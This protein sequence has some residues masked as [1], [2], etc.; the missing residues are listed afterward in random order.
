MSIVDVALDRTAAITAATSDRLNPILIKET[1][2]ATQSKLFSTVFLMFVAVSWLVLVMGTLSQWE[3]LETQPTAE[4]FFAWNF[5]VLSF[6]ILVIVPFGSYRSLLAER[7]L[8]TYDLLRITALSPR[9]IVRGKLGTSLLQIVVYYSAIAPFI[10]FTSVLQGFDV[11]WISWVL[12]MSFLWSMALCTGAL[13]TGISSRQNQWQSANMVGLIM[14]LLIDWGFV[15]SFV[16]AGRSAVNFEDPDF[17]WVNGLTLLAAVSYVILAGQ[18]I[19]ARL[20]FASGNR[21]TGIRVV[22][23]AQFWLVVGLLWLLVSLDNPIVLGSDFQINVG[24]VVLL[25]WTGAGL[26]LVTESDFL[27]RRIRRRLPVRRLWR[28]LAAPFLPGGAT[29]TVLVFAHLMLIGLGLLVAGILV[30][31][32]PD[33]AERI[34]TLVIILLNVIIWVG[35]ASA[36]ARWCRKLSYR[37]T[38]TAVRILT[39][40]LFVAVQILSAMPSLLDDNMSRD[41]IWMSALSPFFMIEIASSFHGIT[42]QFDPSYTSYLIAW[43]IVIATAVLVLVINL[44]AMFTSVARIIRDR[45]PDELQATPPPPEE[46]IGA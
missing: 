38:P 32:D 3:Y 4:L 36:L 45:G 46:P 1:R 35:I 30:G 16:L 6:A 37:F 27:S 12:L 25:H 42:T 15:L 40:T 9:Q 31:G 18:V 43:T 28:L 11:A 41:L 23:V 14:I 26:F 20:T 33:Y 24:C 19:V 17:W 22:L 7:E 13:L 44:P 10:A 34:E 8:H 5:G 39:V 21:S 2:Q 29:G